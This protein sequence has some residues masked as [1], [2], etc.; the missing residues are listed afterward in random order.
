LITHR[1]DQYDGPDASEK[2]RDEQD[3]CNKV[4]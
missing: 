3:V 2:L 4:Y 1:L